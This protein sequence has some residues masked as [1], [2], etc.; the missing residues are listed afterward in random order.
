MKIAV[1][2]LTLACLATPALAI[3]RYNAMDKTCAAVQQ[4]IASNRAVLLSYPSRSGKVV[5][6]DRYVAD[7]GQCNAT[8]YAAGTYVPTKD[9]RSCPVLNC[10]STSALQP[11]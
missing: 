6:Y 1:A 2:A 11:R 8:E 5:L 3:S 10:R 9:D 7:R 4:T